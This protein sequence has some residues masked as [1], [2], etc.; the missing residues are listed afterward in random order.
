MNY[1]GEDGP[2]PLPKMT[3]EQQAEQDRINEQKLADSKAALVES[4]M[5]HFME[6]SMR[7]VAY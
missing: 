4:S 5:L 1:F 7:K 2:V 6:L 3:R